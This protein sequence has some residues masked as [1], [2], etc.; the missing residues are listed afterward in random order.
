ML[1][2]P[3]SSILSIAAQLYDYP[4]DAENMHKNGFR[5]QN[6]KIVPAPRA[7]H[8]AKRLI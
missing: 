4:Q 7:L 3:V 1:L 2:C 6:Q 8:P 5:L